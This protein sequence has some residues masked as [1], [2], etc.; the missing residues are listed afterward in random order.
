MGIRAQL[1]LA[2]GLPAPPRRP[3]PVRCSVEG[4]RRLIAYLTGGSQGWIRLHLKGPDDRRVDLAMEMCYD[5]I[6]A[7]YEERLEVLH[8]ALDARIARRDKG[9]CKGKVADVG[10]V[11]ITLP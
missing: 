6:R 8:K 9:K 7:V 4:P 10:D 11:V 2:F 3:P 1:R 5:L